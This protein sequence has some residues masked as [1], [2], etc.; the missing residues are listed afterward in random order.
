MHGLGAHGHMGWVHIDLVHMGNLGHLCSEQPCA[1]RCAHCQLG[2]AE[3]SGRRHAHRAGATQRPRTTRAHNT[4]T[5]QDIYLRRLGAVFGAS[6]ERKRGPRPVIID[7]V[8]AGEMERFRARER[9]SSAGI[10]ALPVHVPDIFV[11]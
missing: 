3:R 11:T 10:R 5:V 2:W 4:H 9:F 7:F 8:V 1:G 6:R